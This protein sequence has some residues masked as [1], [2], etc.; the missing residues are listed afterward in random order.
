MDNKSILAKAVGSAVAAAAYIGLV[1]TIPSQGRMLFEDRLP[2][3]FGPMAFLMLFSLSAAVLGL[4]IFAR[5]V[6]FYIDGKKREAVKLL[7]YT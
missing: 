6:M 5:P 7:V 1:A 3:I 4:L 2:S